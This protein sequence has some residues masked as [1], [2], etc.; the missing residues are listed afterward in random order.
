MMAYYEGEFKFLYRDS[1][2]KETE[3][4]NHFFFVSWS[5]FWSLFWPITI[6]LSYYM[7]SGFKY[8][9]KFKRKYKND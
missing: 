6:V 3:E 7:T 2:R 4:S 1:K 5:F 9:F 8:G